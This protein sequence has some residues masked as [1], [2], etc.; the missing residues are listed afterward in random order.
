MKKSK[1]WKCVYE[2]IIKHA[3]HDGPDCGKHCMISVIVAGQA[4]V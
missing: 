2:N 3:A 4:N 1:T